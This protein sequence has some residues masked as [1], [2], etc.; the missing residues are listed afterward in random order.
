MRTV[1]THF[2]N[3]AYLLP[4]WLEHHVKMFDHGILID[5]GS[6]D[7]SADICRQLAPHWRLVKSRLVE[8]DAWLTDFEVMNYEIELSGWKI[9]LNTTEF[10]VANPG[11]GDLERYLQSAGRSGIAASGLTMVDKAPSQLPQPDL[12]LVRQKPWAV[13]DNRFGRWR[14]LRQML[15]HPKTPQRN[16]FYHSLPTGMYPPG[17]HRSFHR[18][19]Q[20]RT[21]NLMV[22]HYGYA[23][24]NDHFIGRKIQIADKI[25]ASDKRHGMGFQHLRNRAQLQKAFDRF[26]GL[27]FV[28]LTEH[29]IAAY[30]LDP[31]TGSRSETI[32]QVRNR[33]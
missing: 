28:D 4:W 13:D 15:G 22:L 20:V 9:A 17:R 32:Y 24:W 11:L 12:P 1:I 6:T 14:W 19:W 3:E 25:P 26:D 16:R 33:L 29:P 5:H 31:M 21:P 30:G 18:D 23:P 7:E 10:L 27:A 2:F 8:F